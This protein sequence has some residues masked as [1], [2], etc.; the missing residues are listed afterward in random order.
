MSKTRGKFI[1]FEGID[2]AGKSTQLDYAIKFL[3]ERG[4]STLQTRE[5]GGTPMGES[6]RDLLLNSSHSPHVETELLL[7][8]AA[9]HEHIVRVIEP[10]LTEGKTVV[11]D[12]FTDASFAYP[13]GGSQIDFSR[14][15]QLETWVQGS[16]QPD[17]TLFFDLPI[18]VAQRRLGQRQRDRFEAERLDFHE[19]VRAA[20]IERARLNKS[21]IRV[22]DSTQSRGKIRTDVEQALVAICAL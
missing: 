10:A 3:G 22:I 2:G 16:L 7:M 13:G 9:R 12:R 14:I 17:L 18:H 19:R 21:R 5:P 1:S 4:V 8:F 15:E 11:C 6:L 20:Y